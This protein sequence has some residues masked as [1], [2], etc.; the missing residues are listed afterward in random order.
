MDFIQL[1]IEKE[2]RSLNINTNIKNRN[3]FIDNTPSQIPSQNHFH[4]FAALSF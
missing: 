4:R 1:K 2:N 3:F